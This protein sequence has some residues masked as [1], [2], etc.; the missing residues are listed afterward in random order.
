MENSLLSL[1]DYRKFSNQ[2]T[3]A[4]HDVNLVMFYINEQ[5][6]DVLMANV[7]PCIHHSN[8]TAKLKQLATFSIVAACQGSAYIEGVQLLPIAG[9]PDHMMLVISFMVD[10]EGRELHEN[11]MQMGIILSKKDFAKLPN[12]LSLELRLLY[13][14]RVLFA[15]AADLIDEQ[16]FEFKQNVHYILNQVIE[17]S[18]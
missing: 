13:L 15:S 3:I 10:H 7:V 1:Q 5:G 8:I 16:L 9:E 4:F 12:V 6:P 18:F 2:E 11:Y 17:E 14:C